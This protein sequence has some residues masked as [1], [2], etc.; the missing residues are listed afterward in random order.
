MFL[1]CTKRQIALHYELTSAQE[2]VNRQR[3]VHVSRNQASTTEPKTFPLL[4]SVREGHMAYEMDAGAQSRLEAFFSAIGRALKNKTRMASF[5]TY[6]MGLFSSLERKSAEPI[7][8]ATTPGPEECEPAHHRL[9][10]FL[11][12]SPWSDREVRRVAAQH[13]IEAMTAEQPIQAWIIDDT[14]FLKQGSHSVGV[15][16]QYT[17]SAGKITN[18][19]IGVSLSVT[20]RSAHVPIDFELY[21]PKSWTED[22]ERR[23]EC[24]IPD[25]VAFRTKEKLALAM[26]DRA[27]EDGIPGKLL[28]ADSAYGRS[29]RLRDRLRS[30]GFDYALGIQSN[31]TMWRLDRLGRRMGEA[32]PVSVIAEQLDQ[33]AFRR[34]TWRAGTMSGQRGKLS[35]R[36]AFCRVKTTDDAE[37]EPEWLLIEWPDDEAAPTKFSLTTLPRSMSKKQIIRLLKERY[38]TERVYQEMK[39]ELGLDHFE[40][41][42]FPGWHHHVSV[43][44][45]CYAFVVA[46]RERRFPPKARRSHRVEPLPLAA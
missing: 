5:A 38:R 20:T 26:I 46:E 6:A 33:K 23:E 31:Q 40:G 41:R 9:L 39:G 21:L 11:R 29:Q 28:L 13:A 32:V 14:G 36:F 25:D 8:A 16:R 35:S 10:R 15:Q 18:C 1:P 7:A 2:K 42:S 4:K 22:A 43:V 19:Q 17:G 3:S 24:H 34:L 12:D 44:L 27:V 30:L 45:C 37:S